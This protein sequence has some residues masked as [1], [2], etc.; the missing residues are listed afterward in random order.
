MD[1]GPQAYPAREVGHKVAVTTAK[2]AA[3]GLRRRTYL[4][5]IPEVLFHACFSM[6]DQRSAT[7]VAMRDLFYDLEERLLRQD[8]RRSL[9]EVKALLAPDFFEFGRS[10]L[11][12]NRQQ[13]IDGLANE[14]AVDGSV[15]DFDA[16]AL[17]ETVVLVT[18]RSVR[19][20]PGSGREWHSLRSSIWKL[21]DGRWQMAF[22]QGTPTQPNL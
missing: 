20:D 6:S 3:Y 11:I 18:Y 4:P 10:G 5:E 19:R 12:W 14:P 21:T 16:R 17:S 2:W 8:V 7:V 1:F 13:T 22:H 9:G 15:T